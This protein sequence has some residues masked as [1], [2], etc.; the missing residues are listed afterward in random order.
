MEVFNQLP[1]KT[2]IDTAQNTGNAARHDVRW[3]AVVP[4]NRGQHEFFNGY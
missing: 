3:D 1:L 2:C 4:E